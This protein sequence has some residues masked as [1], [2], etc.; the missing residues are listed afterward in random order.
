MFSFL[1][2]GDKVEESKELRLKAFVS[3]RVIPITE[4][5][6]KMF[7]SKCLGDGLAIIP[8]DQV[9]RAPESGQVLIVNE[10]T[11][12]ACGMKLRNGMEILLHIGLDTVSMNGD[13][14]ISH[15]KEGDR[16]KAGDPL[17]TFDLDK[18]RSAGFPTETIMVITDVGKAT[19]IK[20]HTGIS[21]I[22]GE[23]V[24]MDF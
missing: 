2:K 12:H 10:G 7:S 3:G 6:D 5:P 21:A 23:T 8:T 13:G 17:I 16:V 11:F 1:K 20:M 18:I 15:V 9:L 22:A 4:V 19:D 14:F 24:V